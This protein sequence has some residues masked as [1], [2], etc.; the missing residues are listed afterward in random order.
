M[1]DLPDSLGCAS[2]RKGGVARRR[3]SPV[4]DPDARGVAR[5]GRVDEHFYAQVCASTRA[6]LRVR[7]PGGALTGGITTTR[8]SGQTRRHGACRCGVHRRA[9]APLRGRI[10]RPRVRPVAQRHRRFRLPCATRTPV[11]RRDPTAGR[12]DRKGMRSTK[13]RG[14]FRVRATTT[15]TTCR[16]SRTRWRRGGSTPPQPRRR[17]PARHPHVCRHF[18][19]LVARSRAPRTSSPLC[20]S[21]CSAGDVI[22]AGGGVVDEPLS[23]HER[24]AAPVTSPIL[25]GWTVLRLGAEESR[26]RRVRPRLG[27]S[28]GRR[29]DAGDGRRPARR[30]PRRVHLLL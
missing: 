17:R 21:A 8:P 9:A 13:R 18:E 23:P 7:P 5:H 24:R 27:A 14:R 12:R 15:T 28:Q 29:D 26:A 10:A 1:E 11:R 25:Q 22:V 16:R 6:L 2:R 4:G 19:A 3:D 30:R 20:S